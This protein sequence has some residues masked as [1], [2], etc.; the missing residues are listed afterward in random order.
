MREQTEVTIRLPGKD[1]PG[2]LRRIREVHALMQESNVP[3]V[4]WQRL[5]DY[6]I[7]HGYVQVPEGVDLAAAV[8]NLS[9]ADMQRIAQALMGMQVEDE[10]KAVDPTSAA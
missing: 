2:F 5:G 1:E 9:Q 6:V 10:S 8:E 3:G 7:E 4:W